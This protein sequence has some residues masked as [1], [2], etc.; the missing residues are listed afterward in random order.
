[1]GLGKTLQ[2]IACIAGN[3]PS[4]DDLEQG[5]RT[6][7]VVVP[8]SAVGQWIEEVWKHCDGMPVSHYKQSDVVNQA[9]REYFPIW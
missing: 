9:G 1:M 8:A 6:T 4:Q 7:L 5:L 3:P 2:S